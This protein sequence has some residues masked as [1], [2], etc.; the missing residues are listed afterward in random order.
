MSLPLLS[1]LLFYDTSVGNPA[2]A[3]ISVVATVPVVALVPVVL[4]VPAPALL[5]LP[6][7][8]KE[9]TYRT[10]LNYHAIILYEY[11]T[12]IYYAIGLSD[13][14]LA[15]TIS[16]RDLYFLYAFICLLGEKNYW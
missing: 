5:I 6:L 16:C 7:M 9:K 15:K 8:F 13:I 11:Q 1:S 14:G 3:D 10:V 12:Y 4:G 2:V